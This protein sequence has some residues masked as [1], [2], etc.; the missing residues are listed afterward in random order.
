MKN[1]KLSQK[2]A[3]LRRH[4]DKL[5]DKLEELK[6]ELD[7]TVYLL[8]KAEAE[9]IAEAEAEAAKTEAEAKAA[10]EIAKIEA[11]RVAK[12]EA[13]ADN[14]AA[15]I[16]SFIFENTILPRLTKG[17]FWQ[18]RQGRRRSWRAAALFLP[19]LCKL[20]FFY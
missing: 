3:T 7:L 17:Q 15:E 14:L 5:E 19:P 9:A 4:K 2:V 20:L 16:A 1:D 11:E 8:A 12:A 13:E 6:Q 18:G 10:A